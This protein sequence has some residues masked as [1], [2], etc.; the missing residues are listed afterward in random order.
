[1]GEAGVTKALEIIHKELDVTMAFCGKNR[2]VAGQDRAN[3]RVLGRDNLILSDELRRE[4]GL[5]K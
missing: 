1:M 2:A 4:F 3:E 5:A